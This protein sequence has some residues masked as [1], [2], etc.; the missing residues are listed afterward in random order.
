M[1]I[2]SSEAMAA[3]KAIEGGPM[4][5]VAEAVWQSRGNMEEV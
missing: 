2:L 3:T 4:M 1:L 5:V